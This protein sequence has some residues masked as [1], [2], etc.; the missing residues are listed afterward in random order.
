M[1]E[2]AKNSIHSGATRVNRPVMQDWVCALSLMQQS[3]LLSAIRGCDGISKYH[4]SKHIVKWYRRCVLISAFE[5]KAL[6]SPDQP[7]GGSFTGPII[8]V[9]IEATDE[10]RGLIV[11]TA[12]QKAADSFLDS[13][14]EL[15]AHYQTHFMHAAEII[16]YKHPNKEIAGFWNRLYIRMV[17]AY[18]LWPETEE[19]MDQRLGDNMMTWLDRADPSS[20]CSD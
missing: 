12:L 20:T 10:E 18:H 7:G 15:P 5:G 14:D 6:T 17:H 13:R 8:S 4:K 19:Q 3:V 9:P 1:N 2:T 11:E 16:G